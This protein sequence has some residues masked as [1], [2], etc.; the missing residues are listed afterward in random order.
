[1]TNWIEQ[2][3]NFDRDRNRKLKDEEDRIRWYLDNLGAY[4]SLLEIGQQLWQGVSPVFQSAGNNA[5]AIHN[6]GYILSV[7]VPKVDFLYTQEVYGSPEGI[8]Y[9]WNTKGYIVEYDTSRLSV[10][11]YWHMGK[12]GEESVWDHV[13]VKDEHY[14]RKRHTPVGRSDIGIISTQSLFTVTNKISYVNESLFFSPRLR[15]DRIRLWLDHQLVKGCAARVRQHATI[16]ELKEKGAE[17]I[18]KYI[19]PYYIST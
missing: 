3:N 7:D 16:K 12:Y 2:A 1:M 9:Q 10:I 13:Q 18:R 5:Q 4:R 19:N 8:Y 15:D 11:I 6:S 14:A 17:E